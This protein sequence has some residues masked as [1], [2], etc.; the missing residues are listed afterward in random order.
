MFPNPLKPRL[1]PFHDDL[2]RTPVARGWKGWAAALGFLALSAIGYYGMHLLPLAHGLPERVMETLQSSAFFQ[3][4]RLRTR[5]TGHAG[6]DQTLT[7]L[8]VSFMP[9]VAGWDDGFHKLQIYFLGSLYPLIT[10]WS[11]EACRKRNIMALISLCVSPMNFLVLLTGILMFELQHKSLVCLPA[12][13][14][15]GCCSS[16]LHG[17]LESF[18]GGAILVATI[19]PSSRQICQNTPT[20]PA[21]GLFGAYHPHVLA[22]CR[23]RH[24]AGSNRVLATLAGVRQHSADSVFDNLQPDMA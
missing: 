21:A 13:R 1:V 11:I 19:S 5:Y 3:G 2:A 10:I 18:R 17:L 24:C 20:S 23:P 14:Y 16:L 22:L 12:A 9:G 6:V 15:S 7:F 8:S 4:T